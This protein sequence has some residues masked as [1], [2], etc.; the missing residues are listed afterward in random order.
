MASCTAH[1]SS[2]HRHCD[3]YAHFGSSLHYLLFGAC[4]RSRRTLTT[5]HDAL[6]SRLDSRSHLE[7]P[8]EVVQPSYDDLQQQVIILQSQ[9]TQL[10]THCHSLRHDLELSQSAHMDTSAQLT[11]AQRRIQELETTHSEWD[12]QLMSLHQFMSSRQSS[13]GG[14]TQT[15]TLT[16]STPA[17][18]PS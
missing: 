3:T 15:S 16:H 12:S 18:P 9:I 11:V 13:L 17:P 5:E 10:E 6:R 14:G 2:P 1:Y 4:W 8:H 7:E